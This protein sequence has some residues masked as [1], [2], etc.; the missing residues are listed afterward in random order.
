MKKI[1]LLTIILLIPLLL[2]CR[3]SITPAS[4]IN[5][6][7]NEYLEYLEY[8][9]E[10]DEANTQ[11]MEEALVRYANNNNG[12]YKLI[13]KG[14]S[15]KKYDIWS[16]ITQMLNYISL[17]NIEIEVSLK[18]VNFPNNKIQ[19]YLFGANAINKSV[20]KIILPDTITEIGEYSFYCPGLTNINL[21]NTLT[22]IGRRGFVGCYD[23]KTLKLPNSLN[24][25]DELAFSLCRF[26]S[27]EIPDSVTSIGKSA[28]HDCDN[29][30]YIKLPNNLY[31]IS[32]SMF[33]SCNLLNTITIPASVKLIEKNAFYYD[34]NLE[35]VRFLNDDPSSMIIANNAFIGCSLK[36][37][38]IPSSSKAL[39]ET[40]RTT[41]NL[42]PS[43]NIVRE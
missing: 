28:F 36:T 32:D 43:V 39:D 6:T 26:E 38:Y 11:N 10:I 5:S 7:D 20:K 4:Y 23:L 17:E 18:Y 14:T 9:L 16:S 3:N 22:K 40:W 13:F 12:K 21:P 35:S 2:S 29:L 27:I 25:I 37:I 8:G 19:D 30:T 15:T 42:D 33:E 24:V 31:T 34:R 1:I 41:L